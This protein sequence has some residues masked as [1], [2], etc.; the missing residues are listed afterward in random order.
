MSKQF[1]RKPRN[2]IAGAKLEARQKFRHLLIELNSV[3]QHR[4][5]GQIWYLTVHCI[6]V[7]GYTAF[8]LTAAI[9]LMVV[10]VMASIVVDDISKSDAMKPTR[11]VS[12]AFNPFRVLG[13]MVIAF[14]MLLFR[15]FAGFMGWGAKDS[16]PMHVP[17]HIIGS[18]ARH[19]SPN[20]TTQFFGYLT[21][22][23]V[24][25]YVAQ[26]FYLVYGGV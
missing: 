23:V 19:I 22:V 21:I 20:H 12:M 15:I 3:W 24:T 11:G 1:N 8:S 7:V 6:G 13:W 26:L 25:A 9:T 2:V 14:F 17:G 18:I 4:N 5:L 10:F 16:K